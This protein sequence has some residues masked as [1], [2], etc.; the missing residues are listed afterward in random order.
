MDGN[1]SPGLI[2]VRS[3]CFRASLCF[4]IFVSLC[5]TTIMKEVREDISTKIMT[6][7]RSPRP[8]PTHVKQLNMKSFAN[9]ETNNV[10]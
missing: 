4:Q 6:S 5:T 10:Q 9:I 7:Q 1:F 8:G 3:L 2:C